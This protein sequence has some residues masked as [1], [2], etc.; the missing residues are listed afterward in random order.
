MRRSLPVERTTG[1]AGHHPARQGDAGL[2][3]RPCRGQ[4]ARSGADQGARRADRGV[5][6]GGGQRRPHPLRGRSAARVTR[7][8]G[9]GAEMEQIRDALDQASVGRSP[10]S[11]SRGSASR[12]SS[13]RSPTRLTSTAG[14]CSRPA[15]SPTAT[16][17]PTCQSSISSRGTSGL[18]TSMSCA[19]SA[20]RWGARC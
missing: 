17:L 2:G 13:G 20:T 4:P 9:R 5:R 14:A 18:T 19:R 3:R 10:W 15:R 8:V 1:G 16:R 7:F 12:A 6:A 11:E